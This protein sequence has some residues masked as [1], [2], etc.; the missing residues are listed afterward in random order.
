MN[1]VVGISDVRGTGSDLTCWLCQKQVSPRALFC[2][3]CGTIQ[4]VRAIDHFARLGMERRVDIDLE[5]L[6]RQFQT[7]QKT[8]DPNRFAVRAQGERGLA[9]KQLEALW[10]AYETLRDPVRRGRYWLDLH[11]MEFDDAQTVHPAVQE[12]RLQYE[13]AQTTCD[14]DRV[15][16]QAGSAFEDGIMRLLNSLR[17]QNWQQANASLIELHGI[18]GVLNE[19]R[20]RR[21]GMTNT[22]KQS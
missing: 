17:Q 13:Q 19:A 18:E 5:L 7:L 6:E 8:L 11:H 2:H 12:I 16:R 14:L 10:E 3:H 1:N 15:A 22:D 21:R 9:A 4:P 20:D